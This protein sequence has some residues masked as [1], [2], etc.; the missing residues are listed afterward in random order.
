MQ[1]HDPG[2]ARDVAQHHVHVVAFRA[3]AVLWAG[4]GAIG[5]GPC[6][7]KHNAH[8]CIHPHPHSRPN[9]MPCAGIAGNEAAEGL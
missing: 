8:P 9:W 5:A 7:E 1:L 2:S 3:D 6:L 4:P